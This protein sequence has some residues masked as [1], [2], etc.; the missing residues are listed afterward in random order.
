MKLEKKDLKSADKLRADIIQNR[1]N[2]VNHDW[3]LEKLNE[4]AR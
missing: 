2:T 3:L 4:K 1:S